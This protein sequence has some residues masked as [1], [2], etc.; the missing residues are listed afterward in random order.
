MFI[1][2][3]D[4]ENGKTVPDSKV[5]QEVL[6]DYVESKSKEA[7]S[8]RVGNE[9]YISWLRLFVAKGSIPFEEV[10]LE[11]KEKQI[12]LLPSGSITLWPIGFC[13]NNIKVVSQLGRIRRS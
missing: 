12:G 10:Q 3:Y 7:H 13:D 2:I 8:V 6:F 4:P 1:V 5:E 11:F 9:L